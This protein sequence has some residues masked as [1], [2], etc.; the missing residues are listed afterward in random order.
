MQLIA[1]KDEISTVDFIQQNTEC[2]V[3]AIIR[4]EDFWV[5]FFRAE[6]TTILTHG[7]VQD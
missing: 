2:T 6:G 7:S 5:S 3:F 4:L 1:W